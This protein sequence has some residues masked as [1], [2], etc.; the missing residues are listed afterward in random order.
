MKTDNSNN[1]NLERELEEA[2][3]EISHLLSVWRRDRLI[4][5]GALQ[6]LDEAGIAPSSTELIEAANRQP[7][8]VSDL[9]YPRFHDTR[10]S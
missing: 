3:A 4:F 6:L 8:Q 9:P 7:P 5:R 1:A 2:K 10:T